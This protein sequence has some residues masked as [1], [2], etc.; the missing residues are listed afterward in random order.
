MIQVCDLADL[1][2]MVNTAEQLMGWVAALPSACLHSSF[3]AGS[4]KHYSKC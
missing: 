4:A 1:V 2:A 3:A